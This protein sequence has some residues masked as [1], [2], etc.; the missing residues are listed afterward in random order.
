MGRNTLSRHFLCQFQEQG[1]KIVILIIIGDYLIDWHS[2]QICCPFEITLLL[3][4]YLFYYYLSIFRT[5]IVDIWTEA[6][7][8]G[9]YR[10]CEQ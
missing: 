3:L 5:C 8:F 2:C 9:T 6:S 10:L 7:E 1:K 4:F